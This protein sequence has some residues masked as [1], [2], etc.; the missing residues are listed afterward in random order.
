MR[1]SPEVSFEGVEAYDLRLICHP[2]A[3]RAS[4]DCAPGAQGEQWAIGAVSVTR[5]MSGFVKGFG[6]RP[7]RDGSDTAVGRRSKASRG[8]NRGTRGRRRR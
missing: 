4:V 7:V 6:C 3:V 5:N 1:C 2:V 8:G